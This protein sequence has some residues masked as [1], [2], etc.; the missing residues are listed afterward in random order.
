MSMAFTVTASAAHDLPLGNEHEIANY[1][2]ILAATQEMGT[3]LHPDSFQEKDIINLCIGWS[4]AHP[5]GV[6]WLLDIEM[7]LTF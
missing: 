1:I 3:P 5:E 2:C 4:H 6:L 7:V